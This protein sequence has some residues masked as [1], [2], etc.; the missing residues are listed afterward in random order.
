M[1]EWARLRARGVPDFWRDSPKPHDGKLSWLALTFPGSIAGLPGAGASQPFAPLWG[2]FCNEILALE[3][4]LF[5]RL[6]GGYRL[7]FPPCGALPMKTVVHMRNGDPIP[8]MEPDKVYLWPDG[9]ATSMYSADSENPCAGILNLVEMLI[10]VD[11]DK[12]S[13]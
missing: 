3:G 7:S 13:K 8:K 10:A 4:A 5:Q 11:A 12:E 1:A 2:G 6:A 9:S